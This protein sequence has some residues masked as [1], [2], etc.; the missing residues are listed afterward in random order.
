MKNRFMKGQISLEQMLITSLGLV[1]VT[2][3]FALAI[4]S[5]TDTVRSTQATD[6]VQRI[7][8]SADLVYAMGPGAKTSVEVLMPENIVSTDVFGN[9]VLIRVGTTGGE[10]D[11]IA[12]SDAILNGTITKRSG[13]QV[14]TL[15]VDNSSLVSISSTG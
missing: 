8:K 13:R 1:L 12:F 14:I 11:I 7:V 5:A 15:T 2:V 3:F 10:S 6:T 9:R 4:T